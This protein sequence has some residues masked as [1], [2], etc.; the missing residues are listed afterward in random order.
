[1]INATDLSLS[2]QLKVFTTMDEEWIERRARWNLFSNDIPTRIIAAPQNIEEVVAIVNWAR[3]NGEKD[4]GVR[5][6]GHGYFST[7]EVVIDMRDGFNY[8]QLDKN[9]GVATVGMGQTLKTLDTATHP[10]HIPVGV[11]SH[12][13]TG[14]LLTGGVGYL[15]KA[16]GASSDNI[17]EAT[18]VTSDGKVR[19]CSHTKYPDLF[20]A[21]RGAA[22]N[23]GIVTELKVQAYL[24]PDALCSLRSW[25]LTEDNVDLLF[26]WA[27]Q[28]DVL[29]NPFITPYIAF[30]P[31]P[32]LLAPLVALHCVYVGPSEEDKEVMALLSQLENTGETDLLPVSRV[33]WEVPQTIFD[34]GMPSQYWYAGQTYFPGNNRVSKQSRLDCMDAYLGIQLGPVIPVII[35]EQRG[36]HT[37]RYHQFESDSCAQ[38]RYNQRWECYI[39]SGCSEKEHS[40]QARSIGRKLKNAILK[41]GEAS[42]GG[43][44]H[45]TNDEPSRIEYYY[46]SNSDRVR[47]IVAKYDPH[48]LFSKCNGMNF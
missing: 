35:Y 45:F 38:P 17:L 47:E 22:P 2:D 20:F 14:L 5:A 26:N 40:E 6:G 7:A 1:M 32:D 9:T 41:S 3:E 36:S 25:L 23:L 33:P 10:W 15:S 24:H 27:D 46:G 21:L 31:S 29:D 11:V 28:P 43:R 37:S 16:H 48:K 30:M 8:S 4:I 39:F 13:G 12:T 18:I 44:V 42:A 34:G 19:T